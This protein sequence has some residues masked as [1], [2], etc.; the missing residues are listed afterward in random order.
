MARWW[1][2]A[3]ICLSVSSAAVADVL[4]ELNRLEKE[5]VQ[6][7]DD[8]WE[9][10]ELGYLETKSSNR[11]Q[12]Y[13]KRKGFSVESGIAGIPTAFVATAGS[14]DPVIGILAEFDALPG[15]S[16][17]AVPERQPVVADAPGQ[18]CGHHLF[19]A[20]STSAAVALGRWLKSEDRR[21][22]VRL[23]GTPAEEGGSG[24]V[25]MTRAGLFDDVDVMLHWH[26]A[27]ANDASPRSSTANKSG[28]FR[29]HGVAAHAA[30]APDRGRSAL[31]GVESDEPHGQLDA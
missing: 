14:G 2:L 17:A 16:Q 18:A 21:G 28:R 22:T 11:L 26:P 23:Y 9:F 10:A 13:L 25:Y 20:A 31:D 27:D 12:K 15:L 19:G 5:A 8:L 7:A 29:F 24:K 6:I 1:F 3:S 4:S 30:S